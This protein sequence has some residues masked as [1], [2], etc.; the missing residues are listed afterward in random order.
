MK[1]IILFLVLL[2]FVSISATAQTKR[3]P[4]KTVDKN[5]PVAAAQTTK[6][7]ESAQPTT[8]AP[9][10]KNERAAES[11][12]ES[13]IAESTETVAAP[14]KKNQT[15]EVSAA[16]DKTAAL[17]FA[18]EFAQPK[19]TIKRV[20]IEH[21]EGGAGRISFLKQDLD[22]PLVDPLQVSAK[23]LEKIKA[24]WNELNFLNATDDYQT[25]DKDFSHL[26]TMKLRRETAEKKRE[27]V[28]NWT[29]NRA[30]KELTDEYKKLTEQFVWIFEMNLARE[31]FPL[32]AP[33]MID[34]LESLMRRN[35]ISDSEQ[36]L[37]FLREIG[38]DERLPL[39]A[40]NHTK[41]IV[42]RIEKSKEE[43]K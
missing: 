8:A 25:P 5:P 40:R 41:K 21:D 22:E 27:A 18:Y 6:I 15:R 36:L 20:V 3:K 35:V 29:D 16:V 2:T 26:G 38:D 17:P 24:L 14:V 9:H 28:F 39:I 43:K 12:V 37:P 42:E 23:S 4:R 33:K 34:N 11:A 19:F 31:N 30:A 1:Q 32:N 10:K 7:E 13:P